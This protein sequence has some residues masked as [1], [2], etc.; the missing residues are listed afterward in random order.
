MI[1]RDYLIIGGGVGGASV[2]EGIREHDKKGS[3]TLIGN[4]L[5]LPYSRPSLSKAFLR[6]AKPDPGK[7][8]LLDPGWYD[9]HKIEV[10]LGT[11]A[12]QLNLERRLAVLA[13]GQTIEFGKAC[14]ATGSRPHRPPVAGAS[15]GNIIYLRTLRDALALREVTAVEKNVV[16]VGG[17]LLALEAA[18]ALSQAGCKVSLLTRDESL[19]R[20]MLDS[21]TA[22][23]L[24]GVFESHGV[25]LMLRETLNG[26]E[27]KTVLRNIQTKSGNRFPASVALVAMGADLNLELVHNTPLSS[28]NGT[29]VNECL[30]TEEK[31]VYAIGDIALYPDLVLG[32]VRRGTHW[33]SAILQG[34]VAGANMTGK[35]RTRFQ[36]VPCFSSEL[37][38]IKFDFVGDFSLPPQRAQIDGDLAR[39][40]FTAVHYQGDRP[41]S[42]VLCNRPA[43]EIE[44][45]RKLFLGVKRK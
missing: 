12:T 41:T 42:A 27:G 45:V 43:S 32:G 6:E 2:C 15:L 14:L 4:E 31:G 19:W 8:A 30:E 20:P 37:F 5:Y 7:V 40:S 25:H 26:F 28:P 39:Q 34:R 22:H 29:P 16:V 13:T 21:D 44:S 33:E 24:T 10:R 23:W 18:A 1:R 9:K 35:K 38:G 11:V 3:V 36:Y 17:G